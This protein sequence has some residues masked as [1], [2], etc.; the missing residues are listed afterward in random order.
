VKND[1][2]NRRGWPI[3]G[4]AVVAYWLVVCVVPIF[5]Q[6]L[7]SNAGRPRAD[8]DY[9]GKRILGHIGHEVYAWDARSGR[10]L[11]KFVGHGERI[12][13]VRLSLDG[14]HAVSSSWIDGGELCKMHLPQLHSK[15][16]SVRLW[17]LRTGKEIWKLEGQIFGDLSSDGKRLLTYS[18]LELADPDCE[19]SRVVVMWDV[20]TGRKLFIVHRESAGGTLA[21]SRDGRRFLCLSGQTGVLFDAENGREIHEIPHVISF[22]FYGQGGNLAVSTLEGF[23]IWD[24]ITGQR[25]HQAPVS[26]RVTWDGVTWNENGV[27]ASKLGSSKESPCHITLWDVASGKVAN[28]FSCPPDAVYSQSVLIS[29]DSEWILISWGDTTGANNRYIPPELGRFNLEN[30]KEL[31]QTRS[32]VVLGFSPDGKTFLVGG[33]TFIVYGTD[34]GEPLASFDLFEKNWSEEEIACTVLL[35]CPR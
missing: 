18:R 24:S 34:S 32:G 26:N 27:R 12:D 15:D 6:S 5:A 35:R 2:K 14:E 33:R 9:D 30:G 17:S 10:V 28:R 16:T 20:P 13:S 1:S 19:G 4:G 7:A 25:T 29:P 3:R 31:T 21:F 8:W 22:S 11:H 23:E